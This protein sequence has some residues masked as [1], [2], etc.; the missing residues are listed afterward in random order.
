LDTDNHI[1]HLLGGHQALAIKSNLLGELRRRK[2]TKPSKPL[3]LNPPQ[4][5]TDPDE[6]PFHEGRPLDSSDEEGGLI[7]PKAGNLP[8]EQG[9]FM[10]RIAEIQ[11]AEEEGSERLQLDDYYIDNDYIFNTPGQDMDTTMKFDSPEPPDHVHDIEDVARMVD[12]DD[13]QK[14][15]RRFK[16]TKR[17]ERRQRTLE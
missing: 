12:E 7:K 3:D 11:P 8:L 9:I 14:E 1:T 13:V 4:Y 2:G 6:L 5:A 10:V 17:A 16:N 15:R